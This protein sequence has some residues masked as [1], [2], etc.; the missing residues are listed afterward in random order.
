V[1]HV[2]FPVKKKNQGSAY[3]RMEQR[4]ALALPMLNVSAMVSLS[5]DTFE[6]ARLIVAL[7]ALVRSMPWTR[8]NFLKGPP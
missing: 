1:T 6:W 7:W 4:K 3:L 2:K 5:G 8:R